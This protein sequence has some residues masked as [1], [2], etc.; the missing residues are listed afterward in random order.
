MNARAEIQLGVRHGLPI[1]AYHSGPGVS[2]TGL[3]DLA[4]GPHYFHAWHLDPRRPPEPEKVSQLEGNLAHC[5]ILEPL[6][7]PKR[8]VVGPD[9]RRNTKV[10]KAFEESLQ[11][12][13]TAIKPDQARTAW[14]QTWRVMAHPAA[15]PLIRAGQPEVS[16]TWIDEKTGEL[17]RCRPDCVSPTTGGVILVDV[18]TCGEAS[19]DD[20]SR[21]IAR[22]GYHR[23]AALYSDGYAQ[24]SGEHVVGFVF[25]AVEMAWPYTVGAFMLDDESLAVGRR[26]V[27]DLLDLYAHCKAV[28]DWPSPSSSVELVSLP[29]WAKR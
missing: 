23:Q 1:E 19:A 12:G 26:E 22:M 9:E 18:K 28:D 14:D 5:A 15:G 25:V 24:A 13:Q 10:W 6:E 7:F 20:F 11:P 8:Y 21:Q 3:S 29:A 17:C 16:A 2:N 4:R 27:R